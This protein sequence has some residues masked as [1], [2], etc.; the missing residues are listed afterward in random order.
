MN[1]L[2]KKLNKIMKLN[3]LMACQYYN[4]PVILPPY[5]LRILIFKV[6]FHRLFEKSPGYTTHGNGSRLPIMILLI[7]TGVPFKVIVV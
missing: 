3:Y 2:W 4:T 5:F 1:I 7:L 6:F